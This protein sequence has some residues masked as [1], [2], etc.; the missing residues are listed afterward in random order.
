MKD[1]TRKGLMIAQGIAMIAVGLALLFLRATMTIGL[2]TLLGSILSI[3]LITASL[4]F[5]AVTDILSSIGLAS[6]HLPH[7]RGILISTATA[8]AAGALVILLG[9]M[10]IRTACCVFAVYSLILSAAK[11]HLATHWAGTAQ[12]RA[13]TWLLAAIA[14]FFVGLLP[15]LA[16]FGA[17]ERNALVAIAAYSIFMGVQVLLTMAWVHG[18]VP[19]SRTDQHAL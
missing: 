1:S 8:A 18:A 2:F 9:P 13:M 11:V 4:L 12:V 17:D 15:I 19:A 5:I 6:R 7:L 16:F 10:T 3:L 14:L